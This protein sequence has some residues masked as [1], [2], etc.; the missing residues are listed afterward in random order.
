M[1]R[2]EF[3]NLKFGDLV[4]DTAG[5]TYIYLNSIDD[6]MWLGTSSATV[7]HVLYKEFS[8]TK[9]KKT[10]KKTVRTTLVKE[11]E[12]GYLIVDGND[13]L[14]TL[15]DEDTKLPITITYEIEEE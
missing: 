5:F 15:V 10:V 12:Y 2:T 1:T 8:V 9:P 13:E 14:D 11:D 3:E 4:Y 7:K 6:H